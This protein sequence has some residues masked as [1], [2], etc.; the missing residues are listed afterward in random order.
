MAV[1]LTSEPIA[2]DRIK[3]DTTKILD[4]E[5]I[6]QLMI[7]IP[8]VGLL[9]PIVLIR[10]AMGLGVSLV[11]GLSRLM[12]HKRLKLRSILSRVVNGNSDEIKTWCEQAAQDENLIRRIH[13]PQSDASVV[14]LIEH[15]RA[16]AR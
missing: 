14:S 1:T 12:A 10:P 9:Q 16:A 6:R 4:E 3:F 11:F 15:R 5:I 13:V 7:S 2:T 8:L